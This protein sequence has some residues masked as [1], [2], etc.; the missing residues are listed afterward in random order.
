ML[1]S[2]NIQ[3][4]LNWYFKTSTISDSK[5]QI[6]FGG[7]FWNRFSS[8]CSYLSIYPFYVCLCIHLDASRADVL[9]LMFNLKYFFLQNEFFEFWFEGL[10]IFLKI[11]KFHKMLGQSSDNNTFFNKFWWRN[12]FLI[13]ERDQSTFT[14]QKLTASSKWLL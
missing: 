4:G 2:R 7:N 14:D 9:Y 3:N 6:K 5:F 11:I 12:Q 13:D 8:I 1:S 10:I